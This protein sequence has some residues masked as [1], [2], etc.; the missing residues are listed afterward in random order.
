MHRTITHYNEESARGTRYTWP[1]KPRSTFLLLAAAAIL[2]AA[3]TPT[4]V[5]TVPTLAALPAATETEVAAIVQPSPT[6]APAT[7]ENTAA[8]LAPTE[9]PSPP[10]AAASATG[11]PV[12][13]TPSPADTATATSAATQPPTVTPS[14][15]ITMTITPTPSHTLTPTLDVGGFSALIDMAAR[16][17]VQPPDV[18]YG[19][20]T[21][22]ALWAIGDQI[23][24][25]ALA[26]RPVATDAASL[27]S[28]IVIGT[29][30][31][32][33][34]GGIGA[35]CATPPG[36]AVGV[37]LNSDPAFAAQLGCAIAG[38]TETAGAVQSFER[39]LMIYRASAF[40]GAPG[41]IEAISSDNRFSRYADS[42]ISGVDPDSGN[43][44]PPPGL[45]EP[46]RGFGK[47]WRSDGGLAARLGWALAG[48]Q[49]L[50][51]MVQLF[52]RGAAIYVP[53][54]NT[55]WILADDGPGASAGSWRQVNGGF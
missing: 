24:G 27:P 2:L 5:V 50:P 37:F 52:E 1:M 47:V 33:G 20:G 9:T 48:E 53:A 14:L 54:Q 45:I 41:T 19:P 16:I 22:T 18:R 15:T 30:P 23:A 7:L 31:A 25:T 10:P 12:A 44:M 3:C 55:T 11:T 26:S 43:L 42:W 40:T 29:S 13:A 21:A 38:P 34:T 35:A 4:P 8:A 46:I 6:L 51:L 36:G 49:G 28:V 32:N 17:T 39:G